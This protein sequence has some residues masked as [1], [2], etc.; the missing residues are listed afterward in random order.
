MKKSDLDAAAARDGFRRTERRRP[1]AVLSLARRAGAPDPLIRALLFC[2]AL[3]L[4]AAAFGQPAGELVITPT[5]HKSAA[6]PAA[7]VK[8][9]G[10][11]EGGKDPKLVVLI[12]ADQLRA[13]TL[14]RYR[15]LL[16]GDGLLRLSRGAT[17]VGHYGQQNT[18]TGPGHALIATGSYGYL[19]GITQNKWFADAPRTTSIVSDTSASDRAGKRRAQKSSVENLHRESGYKEDTTK[20]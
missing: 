13:D 19:N 1:G 18:Y 14:K 10:T 11:P 17:A 15:S 9:K 4:P 7:R 8:G 6:P 5:T 16:S 3:V 2:S 20:T 12:V